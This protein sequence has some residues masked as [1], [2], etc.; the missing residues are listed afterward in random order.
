MKHNIISRKVHVHMI[1]IYAAVLRTCNERNC[2]IVLP[3]LIR[4]FTLIS[5]GSFIQV[6]REIS[7]QTGQMPWLI[8]LL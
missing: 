8:C 5:V 7:D 1:Y 3:I 4:V 6:D 2:L